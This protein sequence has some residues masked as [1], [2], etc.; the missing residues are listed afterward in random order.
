MGAA[1]PDPPPK[2]K[3]KMNVFKINYTKFT[4]A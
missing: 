3:N 1:P 4:C 2:K